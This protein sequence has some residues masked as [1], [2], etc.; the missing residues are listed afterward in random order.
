MLAAVE[1]SATVSGKWQV[2]LSAAGRESE[3]TCTLTQKDGDLTGNCRNERGPAELTGKVEG[4]KV[5]WT[6]KTDSEGGPVTLV[7]RG[8]HSG[9]ADSASKIT[10]TITAVEFGVDGEFTATLAK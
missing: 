9:A 2:H 7:Y 6:Y 8:V 5:T 10:G 3:V 4:K 1:D